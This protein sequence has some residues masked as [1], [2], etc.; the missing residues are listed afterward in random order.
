MVTIA[1]KRSGMLLSV[2]AGAYFFHE[3]R[4]RQRLA[5]ALVVL[6]GVFTMYFNL[7]PWALG[8]VFAVA[9]VSAIVASR[10]AR[11]EAIADAELIPAPL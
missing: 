4:S 7:R 5:A 10:T 9:A 3:Q 1:V 11:M 8:L 6:M 2:L